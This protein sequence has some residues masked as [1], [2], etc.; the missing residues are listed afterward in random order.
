M[1]YGWPGTVTQWIRSAVGPDGNLADLA[2]M[3]TP[4]DPEKE[5]P[6]VEPGGGKWYPIAPFNRYAEASYNGGDWEIVPPLVVK[7]DP[8]EE[9][10]RGRARLHA[11]ADAALADTGRSHY[12]FFCYTDASIGLSQVGPPEAPEWARGTY[13][14]VCSSFIWVLLNRAGVRMESPNKIAVGSDLE[15]K[16]VAAGAEVG[17]GSLDGLYLYRGEERKVAAQWLHDKLADKVSKEVK[18]RV[19][20]AAAA[21][22]IDLTDELGGLA[23]GL[24]K[25]FSDIGDDVANQ[26]TNTFASDDASTA[27]K[28]SDAW[29][30]VTDSR[31]VS[32]DNTLFWDP[33]TAGGLYGYVV[34]AAFMPER[35]EQAPRYLWKFV[36]THGALEGV[37]KVNGEPKSRGVVQL[38][39][40]EGLTAITTTTAITAF[41]RCLSGLYTAKALWDQGNGIT[42]DNRPGQR[43]EIKAGQQVLD[44][45]LQRS[46]DLYRTVHV[47]GDMFFMKFYTIGS[48]TAASFP[49]EFSVDLAPEPGRETARWSCARTSTTSMASPPSCSSSRAMARS[50]GTS[51]GQSRRTQTSSRIWP[52]RSAPPSRPSP[53]ASSRTCPAARSTA[54]IVGLVTN[55]G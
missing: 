13:P 35:V 54:P 1:K 53:S 24:I 9:T 47:T 14:S 32:P 21:A 43:F 29:K 50:N 33:P 11:I 20:D 6:A 51:P 34:P 15:A 7:P 3:P 49:Y 22:G 31:A 2:N 19:K 26:M 42:I 5:I 30:H 40:Q 23:G 46:A 25:L 12:R 48:D 55:F 38:N 52:T 41:R 10:S 28:D 39:D 17:E 8:F 16:D 44:F 18:Q 37:L 36:P 27:A 4:G 45:N